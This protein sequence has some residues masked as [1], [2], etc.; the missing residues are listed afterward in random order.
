[1]RIGLPTLL[2]VQT[3][4]NEPRYATLRAIKQARDK[5]LRVLSLSDLGLDPG[6]VAAAA[7]SHRRR[8]THPERADGA[9]ILDGS[10]ADVAAAIVSIVR[11]RLG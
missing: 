4:I 3:G 6:E 9:Q 7:G 8:L 1:L 11:E 2:T 5:P 10:T